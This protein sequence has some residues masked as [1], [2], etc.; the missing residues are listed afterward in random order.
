MVWRFATQNPNLRAAAPFYGPNP[1]AA[2][3][4]KIKAAVL[5]I[6]GE[7][8]TRLNEGIPAAREALQ[9]AN[10]PHEIHIYPQANHAFFNDTGDRYKKDAAD[11]AWR[12]VLAWFDRH[13]KA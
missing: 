2:D 6:Y 4:P 1:P 11:D 13:L 12:R 7:L 9:K 3:F 10:V 8:D 5:A